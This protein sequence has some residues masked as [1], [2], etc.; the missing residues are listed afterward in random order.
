MCPRDEAWL[1]STFIAAGQS[2][3]RTGAG[4]GKPRRVQATQLT[5]M[6]GMPEPP[7]DPVHSRSTGVAFPLTA[8]G[9]RPRAGLR[10]WTI[11]AAAAVIG[12]VTLGAQ[13]PATDAA[14]PL[15]PGAK[16]QPQ[17]ELQAGGS[18]GGDTRSIRVYRW[19]DTMEPLFKYYLKKL[20]GYRDAAV[21]TASLASLRPGETTAISYH[22]AFHSFADQCADSSA[23][24]A[25][26]GRGPAA[27]KAWR[28]AK[29]K[30]R[31]LDGRLGLEPG[32]WIE[33]ATFRWF[34]RG[35]EGDLFRWRLELSDS[36]LSD[37]WQHYTPSTQLTVERVLVKRIAP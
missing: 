20:G 15:A 1:C 18:D 36:G 24:V 27:C 37:D 3:W 34:S 7:C 14:I 22:L 33:R 13:A 26:G 21:D 30:Q 2:R 25:A 16:R 23:G 8:A 9:T 6:D 11:A 10:S 4:R 28:R 35:M 5:G 12:A 31:A 29:D 17:L 32:L 19:A